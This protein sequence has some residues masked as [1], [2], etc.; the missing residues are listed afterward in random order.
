MICTAAQRLL[1]CA[2]MHLL[3]CVSYTG[4]IVSTGTECY[5]DILIALREKNKNAECS[6]ITGTSTQK[7]SHIDIVKLQSESFS[8]S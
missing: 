5:A 4:W 7:K 3:Y 8:L 6:W 2:S 1:C